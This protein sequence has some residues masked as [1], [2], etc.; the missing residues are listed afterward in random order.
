MTWPR[1]RAWARPRERGG[2]GVCGHNKLRVGGHE[3]KNVDVKRVHACDHESSVWPQARVEEGA[4][5]HS[6]LS[7]RVWPK[8]GRERDACVWDKP[9]GVR[10]RPC[11]KERARVRRPQQMCH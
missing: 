3:P 2:M 5:G 9:E 6:E 11:D 4:C 8:R 1:P 7:V 10:P